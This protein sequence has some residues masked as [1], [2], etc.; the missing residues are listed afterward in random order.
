MPHFSELNARFAPILEAFLKTPVVAS[1]L[2][3]QMA[4]EEYRE[5]M[6]EIFHHTRENPQLQVL[7]T[8][9]F[10]GR[11]RNLIKDF[12]KHAASEIGHDQLALC[13]YETLGGDGSVLPYEN[14]LPATSGLL[15]YGFYQIYNL[16]H[17][18][19]LGYLFFLEFMPTTA[20]NS[21]LD[22]LQE[23][24][25]P[26]S[27]MRFLKDH[28]EV[29]LGHNRMMKKYISSLVQTRADLDCIEYSM[30]STAHLYAQ[31]MTQAAQ[32]A[33]SPFERGWNW[34]E[35]HADSVTPEMISTQPMAVAISK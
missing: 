19:Y 32:N 3:K 17:L 22:A 23:I 33:H 26:A 5:I 30:K 16:N 31:M 35:M 34:E 20:G 1:L 14:P 10:R 6:R 27:A 8:V 15:A 29:D 7:A 12:M 13:D 21:A 11:E 4:V 2:N 18:G 28:A 25:V 24:G 9:H